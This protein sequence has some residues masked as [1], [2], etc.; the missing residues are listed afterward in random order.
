MFLRR[1][2]YMLGL[3]GKSEVI[4]S[5][6]NTAKAVGSGSLEVFATPM[7]VAMME[8]AAI[9]ALQLPEEQTSVGTYLN[10]K[11]IAATPVGM[12]VWAEAEIIEVEGRRLVYKIEAYDEKE[13]I[14]E[15]QHER[16]VVNRDKFMAKANSKNG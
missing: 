11:H 16:F 1:L 15:G 8:N 14:G 10:V 4:V 12:K 2:E 3:K 6:N 7:M 13:K 5:V 9:K